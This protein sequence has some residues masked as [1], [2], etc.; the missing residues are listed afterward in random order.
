MEP[1]EQDRYFFNRPEFKAF[2]TVKNKPLPVFG[3]RETAQGKASGFIQGAYGAE[4]EVWFYDGRT[5]KPK[6]G[7]EI[8]LYF[9][10]QYISGYF[11][12]VGKSPHEKPLNHRSRYTAWDTK[13][14]RPFT[15]GDVPTADGASGQTSND[16]DFLDAVSS[17]KI[18]VRGITQVKR[19][20]VRVSNKDK[21][22]AQKEVK[23]A[24]RTDPLDKQ[25]KDKRAVDEKA[26]KAQF[27][28]K[29]S[30]GALEERPEREK[31][32][33]EKQYKT[34]Y[35]YLPHKKDDFSFTFY[36]RSDVW[37]RNFLADEGP[38]E[39]PRPTT[40]PL[41][42]GNAIY[43]DMDE[44]EAMDEDRR[45]R[46]RAKNRPP[47]PAV[48][49]ETEQAVSSAEEDCVTEG[50]EAEEDGDED[51]D[52]DDDENDEDY[53][54]DFHD[55]LDSDRVA[56]DDDSGSDGDD[57]YAGARPAAEMPPPPF[58]GAVNTGT[59]ATPERRPEVTWATSTVAGSDNASRGSTPAAPDTI[60]SL[61]AK[62]AAAEARLK[63]SGKKRK[64]RD[65]RDPSATPSRN[66]LPPA[67]KHAPSS[68]PSPALRATS[69][70]MTQADEARKDDTRSR[71]RS[72]AP[73]VGTPA[74]HLVKLE[75]FK[76]RGLTPFDREGTVD[77]TFSRGG[78][79]ALAPPVVPAFF[80]PF[81]TPA[82]PSPPGF[83][84]PSVP[85]SFLPFGTPAPPSRAP[86]EAPSWR[87]S[88]TP[89]PPSALP[90]P[91]ASDTTRTVPG[92]QSAL[93]KHAPSSQALYAQPATSLV[94]ASGSAA[95]PAYFAAAAPTTVTTTT[96]T[97]ATALTLD[98]EALRRLYG[99]TPAPPSISA[100]QPAQNEVQTPAAVSPKSKPESCNQQ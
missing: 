7:H 67:S 9:G 21:K 68:S 11:F 85:S 51:E 75:A 34:S 36:M 20:V 77:T 19:T 79:V 50:E 59:G 89:A 93:E 13:H 78:S 80:R 65:S 37:V 46:E 81:G 66:G 94:P 53:V 17:L 28:L 61:R 42:I 57:M 40:P 18:L 70:L 76:Q 44:Q 54:D 74:P 15:F 25:E 26:E 60:E 58:K 31:D 96:T 90:P 5:K 8:C 95:V 23:E 99:D 64:R 16:L 97:T 2:V 48:Q 4:F 56:S 27:G 72:S 55:P 63:S 47:K 62:L 1:P 12:E 45:E 14:V 41:V 73:E 29:A 52:D 82:P 39:L 98:H 91:S 43:L 87:F 6:R 84:P 33:N 49:D 88:P 30:F 35:D 71:S 83:R 100:P 38:K 69:S 86:S 24:K 92:W 22:K 10:D 32:P 3:M